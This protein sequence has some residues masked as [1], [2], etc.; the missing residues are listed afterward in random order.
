VVRS[1][2]F[3]L[4]IKF[5]VSK[6]ISMHHFCVPADYLLH[7]MLGLIG[8]YLHVLEYQV[9][10]KMGPKKIVVVVPIGMNLVFKFHQKQ[11]SVRTKIHTG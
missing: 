8:I 4:P 10:I 2:V 7:R 3:G 6:G 9:A 1:S 5:V 11:R